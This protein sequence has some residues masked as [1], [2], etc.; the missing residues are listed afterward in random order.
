MLIT[1]AVSGRA[2]AQGILV[3]DSISCP[4]LAANVVGDNSV[5]AVVT[6]LPP[7]YQT[8]RTQRYPVLYML[9]GA[10][11][12]PEEWLDG[13]TYQGLNL[14]RTLD[15]LITARAIPEMIVVM[16]N[17]DNALGAGWYA[18]SPALGNWE[19][20]IVHDVV[21]HVD[22]RYRTE[23][24]RSSR[25][26][27]GH[28]MG[29]FGALAIAFR[30]ADVFGFVYASSPALLSLT[31]SVGATS[32]VWPALAGIAR[33][34]DA[35]GRLRLVAGMAAALDGST[36]NPRLFEDLP[37]VKRPDGTVITQHEVYDRWNSGMPPALA[38]AMVKRGDRQPVIMIEAGS[39]EA[40]ILLGIRALRGRLDSLRVS[41]ADS[42][43]SGGHVDR[44]RGRL[45]NHMLPAVGQWFARRPREPRSFKV[46]R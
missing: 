14:R 19:D 21:H 37:F 42:T 24:R 44:V 30:H 9:H 13:N 36:T 2:D 5:R 40:D 17:A 38:T 28:S 27:F 8:N 18:N 45:T 6:Y 41:Y 23:A 15:S 1:L 22:T 26:L 16:P 25:A 12:V 31:G 20:F 4:G 29:G 10:T 3:T 32:Q 43:F 33:W 39:E 35:T 7:S 46:R 11:S 34:Q